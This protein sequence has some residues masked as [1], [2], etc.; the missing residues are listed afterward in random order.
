MKT[1]FE[2]GFH[3]RGFHPITLRSR[4][5]GDDTSGVI[6]S[7]DEGPPSTGSI[8]GLYTSVDQGPPSQPVPGVVTSL[9]P[10][11][12]SKLPDKQPA[13]TSDADWAKAISAAVS[14]AGTGY[15]AYTKA[16]IA[17][18]NAQAAALKAKNPSVASLLPATPSS[19]S[20]MPL[21]VLGIGAV[22][23]IGLILA[24]K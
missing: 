22:G 5:L 21:V 13:G 19:S 16:D 15:G 11:T 24:L 9:S 20:M 6:T 23:V 14:A 2:V 7:I 17:K 4:R 10:S 1:L 18:L 3:S 8:P 12:P